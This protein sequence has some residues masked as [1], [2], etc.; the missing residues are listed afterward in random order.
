MAKSQRCEFHFPQG[1]RMYSYHFDYCSFE[2][3]YEFILKECSKG[4]VILF[5]FLNEHINMHPYVSP[6]C[7]HIQIHINTHTCVF[8]QIHTH[9][10]TCA[11]I[12]IPTFTCVYIQI[13]TY[14]CMLDRYTHICVLT[15]I[16]THE[17][18]THPCFL[19]QLHKQIHMCAH[20][21]IH[22]QLYS[23]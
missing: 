4:K 1:T 21:D 22:I 3:K 15:K 5:E 23:Q 18:T 19:L 16:E 11:Y 2:P 17:Y 6:T 14:I 12:D 10:Y 20:R 8:A 13:H 7:V 9:I